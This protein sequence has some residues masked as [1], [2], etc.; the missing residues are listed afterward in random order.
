MY[1]LS[2]EQIIISNRWQ[3]KNSMLYVWDSVL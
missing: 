3:N 2:A 1:Y